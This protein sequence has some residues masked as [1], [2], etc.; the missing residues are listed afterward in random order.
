MWPSNGK[1][2]INTCGCGRSCRGG[3]NETP[4]IVDLLSCL[5]S[6]YTSQ[7]LFH[8]VTY[9]GF[10]FNLHPKFLWGNGQEEVRIH[11]SFQVHVNHS[12]SYNL[13]FFRLD[14]KLWV[15][16]ILLFPPF[17]ICTD[18]KRTRGEYPFVFC[19]K[20]KNWVWEISS[21]SGDIF[22]WIF[23]QKVIPIYPFRDIL[24]ISILLSLIFGWN[25]F[26][27]IYLILSS[28]FFVEFWMTHKR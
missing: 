4:S 24:G 2:K 23:G 27:K 28:S 12:S 14:Q 19:H 10:L 6:T 25:F 13:A 17:V 26:G 20:L 5:V 16:Q 11:T 15:T 18:R 21:Y 3:V 22:F 1:R 7:G 8:Y 9:G